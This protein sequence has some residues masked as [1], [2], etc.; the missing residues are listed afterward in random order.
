M[1]WCFVYEGAHSQTTETRRE[2]CG[3]VTQYSRSHGIKGDDSDG[4]QYLIMQLSS[5]THKHAHI[6]T[7]NIH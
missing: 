6:I 4:V 7:I 5:H 1:L 3:P 2:R